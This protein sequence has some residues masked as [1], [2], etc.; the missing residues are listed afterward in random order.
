MSGALRLIC[1][2]GLTVA[3]SAWV[4]AKWKHQPP[5]LSPSVPSATASPI[6]EQ[7]VDGLLIALLT[8]SQCAA[9]HDAELPAEL[10][11][12][13]LAVEARA[14]G[15]KVPFTSVGIALDNVPATGAQELSRFTAFREWATGGGRGGLAFSTLF[16]GANTGADATPSLVIARWRAP[17]PGSPTRI[18]DVIR[19][20]VG[21]G[22]I[23][24]WARDS[25]DRVL[26]LL[27]DDDDP[28]SASVGPRDPRSQ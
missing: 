24:K 21:L 18:V 22:E 3:L 8:S 25:S 20:Y 6:D 11:R 16:R 27:R 19:R 10:D 23:R 14:N 1:G 15:A 13:I 17:R 26:T 9:A 28:A 7:P 4:T 2:L 12:A 5:A